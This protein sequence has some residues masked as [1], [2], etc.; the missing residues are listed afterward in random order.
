MPEKTI[1]SERMYDGKVVNLRVDTVRFEDGREAKREVVEHGGAVAIVAIDNDARLLLVR[2]FRTPVGDDLLEVPAGGI[3]DGEEPEAAAQRELQEETGYRAARIRRLA[4][5]WVAPG[6]CTEFIHVFLAEGLTESRL[7][8]D[9]DEAITVERFTLAES[10][11]MIASGE[12][13]DA[14]SIVGIL[15]FA[16]G[17]QP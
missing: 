7:D 1:G 15:A 16:R 11:A 6:Y 8:A 3:D 14:K 4:G 2:Q 17:T 9:D 13:R 10:I 5:F 12:I